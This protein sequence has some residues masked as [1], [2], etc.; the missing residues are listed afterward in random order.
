MLDLYFSKVLYRQYAYSYQIICSIMALV[1]IVRLVLLLVVYLYPWVNQ[2][3]PVLHLK[4]ILAS[5]V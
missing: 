2:Q 3:I 4:K 1:D 5:L